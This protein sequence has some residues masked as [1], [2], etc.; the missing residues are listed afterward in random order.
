MAGVGVVGR[1]ASLKLVLVAASG[2]G[3]HSVDVVGV[4]FLVSAAG[5]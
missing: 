5:L 4:G 3:R 2:F 1:P